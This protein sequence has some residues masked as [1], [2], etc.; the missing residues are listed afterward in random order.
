[1]K[2]NL[3]KIKIPNM[4][5]FLNNKNVLYVVFVIAI[6]NLLGYLIT[7]NLEAVMFF[8]VIGFLSTYFSK[9][10]IVVLIIAIIFTY[11]FASIKSRKSTHGTTEGMDN[12]DEDEGA[13]N[14]DEDDGAD[15]EEN[16]KYREQKRDIDIKQAQRKYQKNKTT[17]ADKSSD[18]SEGMTNPAP[19]NTLKK[20]NRID[21]ANNLE[22]AYSNL[23]KNIG[24]GGIEGL[25]QQTGSLLNQ[26]KELMDN[27]KNM[28][29]F[30][31][32]AES[33]MNNLDLSGLE[34]I[35]NIISK[36]SGKKKDD[37]S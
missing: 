35:G 12:M 1:M 11:I 23:Q 25:T 13:D 20:A 18:S 2:F 31:Q 8:L 4:D 3:K 19:A 21:Y 10:M 28:Q 26:Q 17:S 29:P 15:K 22:E 14:M 36:V 34:G 27:I 37:N 30:L 33:F 32:T 5:K 6:L 24:K 16:N 7:N 9:N